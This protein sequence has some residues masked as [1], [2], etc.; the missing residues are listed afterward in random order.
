M[1]K[2]ICVTGASGRAGRVAAWELLAHGYR[3]LATDRVLPA[4]DLGVQPLLL[5]CAALASG[6]EV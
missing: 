1:T 5:R 6:E 3:V 4:E 2:R